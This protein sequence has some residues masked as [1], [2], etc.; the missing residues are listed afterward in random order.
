MTIQRRTFLR[1]AGVSL[2]L[3]FLES[4][5]PVF[6]ASETDKPR[7]MVFICTS[8]G[9]HSPNLWPTTIGSDYEST[10]YLNLLKK[11]RDQFTLFGGLSHEDQTGRQP[12]DSELTW[13]TAA[14][15]PGTAGFRNT[16]SI[17][18][19][20]AAKIGNATRFSSITM[21]TIK[22]QSQSYT[23]GGVMIPAETSP[24]ALFANMFL[25]GK[26]DEIIAQKR[27]LSDGRSILDELGSQTNKL[28]RQAS[29]ADNHLLDDYFG[30][31][32]DAE[33]NIA[34]RAGWMDNPKPVVDASQ[35]VDINDPTDLI[36]RTRLLMDLIPLIVQTDS[37]RV[38]SVMVQDHYVVPKIE[39]VTGNH[40]NLSHHGQDPG[41]IE[42]L[43]RIESGIVGCFGDLLTKMKSGV[44]PGS[45]LLDN[46]SIVFGSNLGNANAHDARNLPIFL[47]G[48]GYDHGRF[49]DMKRAEDTPLSN[50]FVR[51]LQD[52]GIESDS[53]GQST[54]ALTWS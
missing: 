12:H 26:P 36:G 8:L 41:K 42:Q 15:K 34:A 44:E 6:G 49:I 18:Q 1:A 7:R 5:N 25:Q 29:E 28:R 32:R 17:D 37:S 50:L 43:Q 52:A 16:I 46:T 2:A 33:K 11:H 13:L 14:R 31:V 45:T 21:G 9:L 53:F 10:P 30:S 51:L 48:G 22:S 19:L 4:M 24:A 38:I 54:S 27:R 20:A 23:D 47:A 40:H 39:G 35:P 3:P